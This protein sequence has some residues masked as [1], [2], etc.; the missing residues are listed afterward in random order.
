MSDVPTAMRDRVGQLL[1][2]D[3]VCIGRVSSETV[4]MIGEIA[5]LGATSPLQALAMGRRHERADVIAWLE[6]RKRAAA[7]I[8]A[9]NPDQAERAGAIVQQI[10]VEIDA[11]RQGL[12]EGCAAMVGA[13]A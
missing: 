2:D 13:E 7:T 8:A 4:A 5:A 9:K 11:V 10:D 3:P 1:A 12:H 6:G